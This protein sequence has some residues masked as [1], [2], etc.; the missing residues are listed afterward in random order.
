VE[1]R[2]EELIFGTRKKVERKNKE[3]TMEFL[4]ASALQFLHSPYKHSHV[5]N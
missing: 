1:E 2:E 3:E 5:T 4:F